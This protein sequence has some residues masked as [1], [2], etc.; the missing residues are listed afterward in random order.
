MPSDVLITPATSK[1]D[2][3][4][5]ANSTKKLSISGTAFSFDSN[6]NVLSSTSLSSAFKAQGVNGTLFEIIDDLSNSL[7]SVN[8]IGGLPVFEVFANNSII[9]GQYNA[10]DFVI[11]GNKIGLGYASP[12]NKLSISGSV[13]IG[14]SYNVAAPSNGLIVQGDVGI[15]TAT[16]TA[17]TNYRFLQVNGPVSAIIETTVAGVRIGGFDSTSNTLY[18]GTIGAFPIVFRTGVDE[19]WRITNAGVLQSSTAQTIQTATGI[20]T[21]ATLAGDGHIVLSPHGNG[22]VGVKTATPGQ[23]LEVNGRG[24]FTG[25]TVASA[26]SLQ[27]TSA[28]AALRLKWTTSPVADKNTWEIR[29]V[30]TGA[31][32]YLQFRTINDA[33]TVFTNRVAFTN[34]GAVGIGTETPSAKLEINTPT[35]GYTGFTGGSNVARF[36][37]LAGTGAATA[38]LLTNYVGDLNTDTTVDLDF[39]AVDSNSVLGAVPHARIGYTGAYNAGINVVNEQEARGYFRIATRGEGSAG[40]L[41][42]KLVIDYL[43][44]SSFLVGNVGVGTLTARGKLEIN[45]AGDS[46]LIVYETGTPPYKATLELSSQ[47]YGTYGSTIQY[48]ASPETLTI[49][50]YGR[51][52]TNSV[53]GSILFRTKINNT[54]PTDVMLI[55]GFTGNVGIGQLDPA[56]KLD[57]NGTARFAGDVRLNSGVLLNYN[58][59]KTA[60]IYIKGV[61]GN[62]S[63]T[64]SA[65]AVVV[66]GNALAVGSGRGL[67]LTILKKIDFSHVS[68]T[69]YDTY[70]VAGDSDALA[71]VLNNMTSAQI[72]ILTS[73]DAFDASF[74]AN[75][76]TVARKLGLSKLSQNGGSFRRPYAAIFMASNSAEAASSGVL[77]TS[78]LTLGARYCIEDFEFTSGN[79]SQAVIHVMAMTDGTGQGAG[80]SGNQVTT[81]LYGTGDSTDP[82]VLV[83]SS[84]KVGIGTLSPNDL[85]HLQSS[86]VDVYDAT[87]DTGQY[88]SGAGITVTNMDETL[89][90]F[91]QVNLQVSGNSGRAVGRI[92]AIRTASATSDLAFVT[93]N[94]NVKAEKM[95]ILSNGNVGIGTVTPTGK[96]HVY[97]GSS[98]FEGTSTGA[99]VISS[100]LYALQIG[101]LHD[102]ITTAGTYYGGIAFNHLLNYIG[103]TTWNVAPQAWIGTRL[104]DTAGSERDY[105]VFA[106][107]PGTGTSGAGNDIP[108]ERMCIDPNG[109]VGIGVTNPGSKLDV[110]GNI[111]ID[112][113]SFHRIANDS[114]ITAPSDHGLVA[115]YGFDEGSGLLISDKTRRNNTSAV[116]LSYTTTAIRGTALDNFG[117]NNNYVVVPDSTDFDFGTGDFAV[118]LWCRPNGSFTGVNN[119]LIEI[120]LY[121]AGILIRP[122][123][124]SNTIEVYAQNALITQPNIVWAANVWY[125]IVVTRISSVLNVYSNGTRISSVANTSNIQVASAG[126]IGRSAHAVGQFFSGIIDEVKIY[127]GKGLDYGEVRG[128]Y[129]SR[130]GSMLIAP[131]FSTTNGNVGIGAITP[132]ANLHVRNENS[133]DQ[134]LLVLEHAA[135]YS[136]G[137]ESRLDFYDDEAHKVAA[138]IA[139]YFTNEAGNR[140]GLKFYTNSNIAINST[141]ALTL[142]GNNNVGVGNTG[143]TNKLAVSGSASIGSNYNV[144]APTNGLIVEGSVGIGTTTAAYKLDVNTAN[145]GAI[146]I[147]NGAGSASAGLALAVGSGSPWLDITEGA[148]FRIKGNTYANLG[149]WNSGSNTKLLINSNGNVGVGIVDPTAKL[150]VTG[151]NTS[152]YSLLLRSGDNYNGTDSVQIAFGFANQ[153]N[154][155]HSIRTRHNPL[156]PISGVVGNNIDFYVWK[157]GTDIAADLG[158]QFVMTMQGDGNVGIGITNPAVKLHINSTVAGDTLVRADGTN[159]TLFSVVDDLS[160][161][162]MSVNNSAG[163]PVLEVFA[164]DRIVAGQY[165]QNDLVVINNK[166]GIGTSSPANKLTVIG[167]ASIGSST[168]NVAAPSNGLIVQ[169]NVGIGVTTNTESKL[170]V[171]GEVRIV[172]SSSYFTHL[173]Y[174]DGGSNL[175]S[176][177]NGGSTLFRGSANNITSMVV[178]G[179]GTVNTNYNTYLAATSGNVGIGTITPGQKLEVATTTSNTRVRINSTEVV[180]TEYFRSGTGVWLVG[181][182]SSNSFKIARAS[183][184]GTNDYL[185]INS[186]TADVTF[187]GTALGARMTL[188]S[189]GLGIGTVSPGAKLDVVGSARLSANLLSHK[190][191]SYTTS[192]PG[193]NSFGADTTDSSITYY[194]T[195]KLVV[196]QGIRG[197]VWTGKHYIFT[198][199]ANS[200]AYFYDNNFVQITNAYGYYFVTLPL[201]S[202]YSNV[203]GAAWDGRYLWTVCYVSGG[204]T[205]SKIV[206]YDLDTTNQTAT[207]IAESAAITAVL[208]TFDIE[209]ADGHLY[210]VFSGGLY[211][212]KWNG[213][214]IDFVSLYPNAAGSITAQSITYD[215]S[216]LWVATNDVASIYKVGLDGTSIATVTFAVPN[217]CGW[218]WNGSNIVTFDYTNRNIFIINTTRLRIDTQK[219]ALMGGNVGI[220]TTSP[221]SILHLYKTDP[222]FRIQTNGGSNSAITLTDGSSNGYLIKNVSAGTSNGALAGALYTYTD[223]G[224]AFQHIHNGTPLFTILSGGNV[225]IGTVTPTSKLLIKS[226]TSGAILLKAD[227][228]NGTLFSVSDDLSNSLMSVNTIGGLP[229]FEVF[230][231]NSIIA[232]QYGQNDFVISGNKVGIGTASP[233]AK[234]QIGTGTPTAATGG[235]QFGDD[236]TARI[237]RVGA[238]TIQISNNLTV[239]GTITGTFAGNITGNVTG[240][241]SGSS[242]TCSGLAAT[243][244]NVAWS[245]ITSKPTTLAGFGITDALPLTGGTLTGNLTIAKAGAYLT[246]NGTNSDAEIYWQANG[247]SRW[248]M[249]MNVGDNT[250]NFN[251]YNYTTTATN[252]TIL[253]ANGNVGINQA[254]PSFKLDVT[255]TGRFTGDLTANLIGNVTGNV[256]GSSGTCSGLAATATN[257]AWSGITSKPT[258]LSGFGIT[259]S[260]YQFDPNGFTQGDIYGS[261]NMQRLWGTDSVQDIIAFRPPTTVEYTTDNVNWIATSISNEV[262]SGKVFGK[263]SGFNMNAGTNVGGWTKVR[264]TWVNFGYHFFSHFTMAHST[265]GH[266]MNF[267]FYKSDLNGVFSSES[268]RLNGINS[269]PGY[270][271]TTH[272][273]VSGWWDTRD[274]RMVFEL[275]GN[276]SGANATPQYPINIGHI[277]ILGGY[278]SFNR[279][280]DWDGNR[281]MSFYGTVTATNFV[282]PGTSLTGT[283]SS[284]VAGS[285]NAIADGVVSTSAKIANSVVTLAKIENISTSTFL[286]N[287]AVSGGPPIALTMAQAASM[288]SGQTFNTAGTAAGLSATLA[289]TSGGTGGTTQAAGRTGLGATTVGANLFTVPD[290]GAERYIRI[291]AANTVT[292]LN[293]ADFRNAIGAGTGG[294]SGTVTNVSVVSANGFNGSVNTSTTTPAITILTTITGILKGNSTAI[295]AAAAGTDYLA[296]NTD[297]TVDKITAAKAIIQKKAEQTNISGAVT[298]DVSAANV[299]VLNLNNGANVTSI[300]YNNRAA[301]PAVNT[302]LLVIKYS[303]TSATIVW[304]NV[305]WANGNDPTLTKVNGYAD[306]YALTSYKGASGYWIGTV[307]AQNLISTNL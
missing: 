7:M 122:Q 56:Y 230:A 306:V 132:G 15:G 215:G 50:N 158:S 78:G 85:L 80:F 174:L 192:Y 47:V 153:T 279:V 20:L 270:T 16:P 146:R 79:S 193:I 164:D 212:Y 248:A 262:F 224:K 295:S 160:D 57:V 26:G 108:I 62:F 27:V 162:L 121:T 185:S 98:H 211:I 205:A 10:N 265:N 294:G 181:S 48:N 69:L 104:Q 135:G 86:S 177:S 110:V 72:G 301:D 34:D 12:V 88:G 63:L 249:G 11:L 128:Q 55:N 214:S 24:L 65:R 175:I 105:L 131:I 259:D 75:L 115:Y 6:L 217:L 257:V 285:A 276:N 101:P 3:T 112:G 152:G 82:V 35:S 81:A 247:T 157:R 43:G 18:V 289:V 144:A 206:G 40:V 51:T 179:D 167:A 245:G 33:N 297:I 226:T 238:A 180:A 288:L 139:Q 118:S 138:R 14:A 165:G 256:S 283:A 61:G 59:Y 266:S 103:A 304:S 119:T 229:V 123:A 114:I 183:N 194:D 169:G 74:T 97:N 282:G 2:F 156:A 83:D 271:F 39:A 53:Q 147:R 236:I 19:K 32:P 106:T 44:N 111:N 213:S 235:I 126:Y 191:A 70:A 292:L 280:Y 41:T 204:G 150:D 60:S 142:M 264:M 178:Y 92:V 186:A 222:E 133:G 49:E 17:Q 37:A 130:G 9:A 219:L 273:N 243:A 71:V 223:S 46:R 290:P 210:L 137:T 231:N 187:F 172:S 263:W 58:G 277:G 168:Y 93:E 29:S 5:G 201:P 188:N 291:N 136:V 302:I 134:T 73:S 116:G 94:A 286:G 163:L 293:A 184:F 250:E 45:N 241:V 113:S 208:Y 300:T 303:G 102:R 154:Y 216:Y 96:L 31:T 198:D 199:T 64:G 28:D 91:A 202:G 196:N 100:G 67:V 52:A 220:G 117:G 207:I 76:R 274:V 68:S 143:P 107:K 254:T 239:G 261:G 244:T 255:G 228:T 267:V 252:F 253:K 269:W 23:A 173:N 8:T 203:H 21:L 221:S 182:D 140:W 260:M 149:T 251:I 189:T 89:Q 87:S 155:R 84:G 298:I 200:R 305:I 22:N 159:G 4:D 176:S 151:S 234:L 127:N 275:I 299:H 109:L 120:G 278:S 99:A 38:L 30:G 171:N 296:P 77:G 166:V 190:V 209:Y 95:R 258:T 129:L 237:Y 218:A 25:A 42:D 307:V 141:P 13:S 148:E 54:T 232:G 272:V 246:L 287:N 170:Q 233:T 225:G 124:N 145:D 36:N 227:G 161:S 240:N 284:L 242:G 268:Y 281:N 125:H 90:S 195:G 197:V 66:N 1:I